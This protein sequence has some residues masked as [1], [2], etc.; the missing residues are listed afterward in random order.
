MALTSEQLLDH[1][2]YSKLPQV[3]RDMD[4]NIGFPF[5]RYLSALISGGYSAVLEDINDLN[6]LVDPE[7][8][9]KEF[10]PY[11]CASFGLEYFADIDDV[12]QRRLLSNVGEIMRRRGTY[13]CVRYLVRALTG[14]EVELSYFRGVH[15][16]RYGR[17][18][19]I[20]LLADTI[21]DIRYLDNSVAVVE[22][23]IQFFIPYYIYPY[24]N[25]RVR[26]QRIERTVFRGNAI[27]AFTHYRLGH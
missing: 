11:L 18:L 10:L 14:L 5:R 20:T 22:R 25:S 13:S 23:Y 19:I 1:L 4:S 12:Y 8:C 16:E 17:H 3:Y 9:P 15:N 27:T 6:D 7:K 21:N 24:I 26:G 2:Y